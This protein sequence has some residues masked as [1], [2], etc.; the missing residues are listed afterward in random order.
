MLEKKLSQIQEDWK[1]V[2]Q[3][4]YPSSLLQQPYP[5]GYKAPSVILFDETKGSPKEHVNRFIDALGPHVGCRG[6]FPPAAANGLGCCKKG[7]LMKLSPF[8]EF[9]N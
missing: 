1:Y 7:R 5:K 8:P 4:P 3:P 6:L 9:E 2:P